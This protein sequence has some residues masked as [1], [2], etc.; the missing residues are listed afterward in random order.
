MSG[1]D[2]CRHFLGASTLYLLENGTVCGIVDEKPVFR[3]V[4]RPATAN[5]LSRYWLRSLLFLTERK[6]I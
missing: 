4:G 6:G 2:R 3:R 5:D 1:F